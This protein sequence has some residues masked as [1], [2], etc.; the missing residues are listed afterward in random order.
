MLNSSYG[1]NVPVHRVGRKG[2]REDTDLRRVFMNDLYTCVV[3]MCALRYCMKHGRYLGKLGWV[4]E[5][6][7]K[8]KYHAQW[9]C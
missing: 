9:R 2:V 8:V 3:C 5:G 7:E 1:Q 6:K 4:Q